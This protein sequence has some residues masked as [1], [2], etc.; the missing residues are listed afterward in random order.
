MLMCLECFF[1]SLL[2]IFVQEI[3]EQ[4]ALT[5]VQYVMYVHEKAS[6]QID[7]FQS[8]FLTEHVNK[9]WLELAERSHNLEVHP[10]YHKALLEVRLQILSIPKSYIF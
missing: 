10:S 3:R 5:D 4:C 7:V 6:F 2:G 1:F 9:V 8:A